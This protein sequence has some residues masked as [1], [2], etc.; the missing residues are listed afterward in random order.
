MYNILKTVADVVIQMK[1]FMNFMPIF[2]QMWKRECEH[3]S[4]LTAFDQW[5]SHKGRKENQVHV[6]G[7]DVVIQI[8]CRHIL[9]TSVFAVQIRFIR[10]ISS[11]CRLAIALITRF[12]I[13]RK[14]SVTISLF[15]E[16]KSKTYVTGE[17][18]S[19]TLQSIK[20]KLN[21]KLKK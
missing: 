14:N 21:S 3:V 17:S 11:K 10:E 4:S 5:H 7:D 2:W 20:D 19:I 16:T 12:C 8:V 1:N 15:S 9:I 18:H 13:K 6:K